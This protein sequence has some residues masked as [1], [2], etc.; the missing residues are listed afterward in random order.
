MSLPNIS[1]KQNTASRKRGTIRSR[2]HKVMSARTRAGPRAE[3]EWSYYQDQSDSQNPST[4]LGP[5]VE[6]HQMTTSSLIEADRL[7]SQ[8]VA[9]TYGIMGYMRSYLELVRYHQLLDLSVEETFDLFFHHALAMKS[10]FIWLQGTETVLFRYHGRYGE[11]YE[12][13]VVKREFQFS[14]TR[15]VCRNLHLVAPDLNGVNGEWTNSDDL[16]QRVRPARGGGAAVNQRAM[17]QLNH[18]AVAPHLPQNPVPLPGLCSS[19]G[20]QMSVPLAS[21]AAD[22]FLADREMRWNCGCRTCA[23]CVASRFNAHILSTRKECV[24]IKCEVHNQSSQ[25]KL[26]RLLSRA[27][28]QHILPPGE[29]PYWNDPEFVV[30][31]PLRPPPGLPRA[32][33]YY[34]YLGDPPVQERSYFVRRMVLLAFSCISILIVY[35]HYLMTVSV[36]CIKNCVVNT[37]HPYVICFLLLIVLSLLCRPVIRAIYARYFAPEAVEPGVFAGIDTRLPNFEYIGE[38]GNRDSVMRTLGYKF[39]ASRPVYQAWAQE[40]VD[41]FSSRAITQSTAR[42]VSYHLTRIATQHVAAGGADYDR[43]V[44]TNTVI[45]VVQTVEM[46]QETAR[47]F[48]T[49]DKRESPATIPCYFW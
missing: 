31:V 4:R 36:S 25:F 37:W 8:R 24:S 34:L 30:Q 44:L 22:L 17:N 13:R 16:A 19:C 21:R 23:S 43:G 29:I 12:S 1:S 6:G 11:R 28:G 33:N 26:G 18:V 46:Q 10:S 27:S 42:E 47:R 45:F 9:P 3:A 15:I 38:A 40:A 32:V 48:L 20:V 41:L 14:R 39:M 49:R 2:L 5:S 7:V 35:F